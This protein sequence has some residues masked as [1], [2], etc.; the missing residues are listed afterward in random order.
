[1]ELFRAQKPTSAEQPPVVTQ[2]FPTPR[3]APTLDAAPAP[4]AEQG[5]VVRTVKLP[6]GA[7]LPP[8]AV[9]VSS[10]PRTRRYAHSFTVQ[11]L[12]E[13]ICY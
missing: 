1:M 4:E 6:A 5:V 10:T 2:A 3:P 13:N 9:P 12:Q 7:P 11:L 8:G